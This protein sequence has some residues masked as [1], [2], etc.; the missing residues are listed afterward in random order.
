MRDISVEFPGV[1]ALSSV[2]FTLKSGGIHAL[3][4]AN[5]AGKSTL[6]KVLSGVNGGYK[7]D[8]IIDGKCHEIRS[9]SAAKMLGIET[10]YQEVD[11]SLFPSLSV[12]ENIMNSFMVNNMGRRQFVDWRHI[13]SEARA[14]LEKLGARIDVRRTVSE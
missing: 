14:A 2:R 7:G 1:K 12:A 13:R 10:V 3:A 5:G 6:M 11:T 8:I 9:P 4:G